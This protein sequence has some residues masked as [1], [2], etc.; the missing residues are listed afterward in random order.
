MIARKTLARS[1]ALA[2]LFGL[3]VEGRASAASYFQEVQNPFGAQSCSGGST[4]C[5]T[6]YTRMTDLDGDGDLDVIF[7]N[8]DGFFSKGQSQPTVVYLNAGD[9]TFTNGSAAVVGG[10]NGW[11]RQVAVADVDM[12]GHVDI[13][14]PAAWGAADKLFMGAAGGVFTDEAATRLPAGLASNAGATRFGDVDDDGDLDLFVGDGWAGGAS[15]IAHLY[16]NDGTGLFT[17]ASAQLP[18]TASGSELIDFDLLDADGDFDLDLYLDMHSGT[19]SLWKNDGLGNFTDANGAIPGQSGLKYGPAVCDVDG[20]GDLDLWVD[21]TGPGYTERLNINDGTGNFSDETSQRVSGN[22]GAD[23]NGV[24]CIDADGDGDFDAA[25]MSLS[26]NERILWNDGTGHFT[27]N[28]NDPGFPSVGD[29]TLWFDF[30]DVNGDGRLDCVT[31][32]GE[33]SSLDRLYVGI[34]P[35]PIDGKPPAFR[36]VEALASSVDTSTS[37]ILHFAVTDSV[38]T[39]EGPRLAKAFVKLTVDGQATEVRARFMGGDLFR[40]A[41]PAQAGGSSVTVEACATDVR[42][43]EA[44]APAQSYVVTGS[45]AATST[46]SGAG[47]SGGDATAASTSGVGGDGSTSSAAAGAGGDPGDGD[48]FVVDDEGC[49]CELP[50]RAGSHGRGLGLG[51][52]GLVLG[53]AWLRRRRAR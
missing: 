39:D 14:L 41:L 38:V 40:A 48:P 17:D 11:V 36:G 21:N 3:G 23:D 7:P 34:A 22:P 13:Y 27:H 49:G 44:C 42:G 35:A 10:Y 6:N 33:S 46:S 52:T 16:L 5:W 8:A 18:L 19:G 53:L 51:A 29:G 12:D 37:P 45:A 28:A 43:N 26:G 2:L 15:V 32:Q 30:G 31:A 24:A 1:T 9:G 47:G 20:D 25:V 50:G 4:G